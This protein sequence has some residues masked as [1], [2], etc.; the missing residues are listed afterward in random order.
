[1]VC[2]TERQKEKREHM[3]GMIV[4]GYGNSASGLLSGME[5]AAGRPEKFAAVDYRQEDSTD[6]L[7]MHLRA[8]VDSLGDLSDG[9]LVFVD[10]ADEVITKVATDLAVAYHGQPEMM[11]VTGTNLGS[12]IQTSIARGYV[13]DLQSLADLALEN[14][15]AQIRLAAPMQIKEE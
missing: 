1:M 14:A 12:L 9:V 4:A 15:R 10:L 2:Y 13:R 7:E 6:D 5:L 11:V 8:A 3:I